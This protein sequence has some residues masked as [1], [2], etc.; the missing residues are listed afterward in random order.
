MGDRGSIDE[1]DALLADQTTYNG[2]RYAHIY[3]DEIVR[4]HGVPVCIISDGGSQFT[5]HFWR[6]FQGALETQVALSTAFHPQMDRRF[7]RTIQILEGML[8]SHVLDFGWKLGQTSI[9]S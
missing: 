2:A 8:R 3:M 1:V 7:K 4:L 9:F 6:A 5:L